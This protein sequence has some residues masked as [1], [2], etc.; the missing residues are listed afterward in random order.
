MASWM[1]VLAG[2]SVALACAA[3]AS[4]QTSWRLSP[5]GL[6]PVR[7]GMS[8]REA[9]RAL[10]MTAPPKPGPEAESEAC[11]EFEAG[12][13]HPGVFGMISN[14]RL[15]RLTINAP[16]T[17]V[18]DHGVGVGAAEAEVVK[19]YGGK[20]KVEPHAYEEKPAHYLTSRTPDRT[21]AIKYSTDN[22]RSVAGIDAGL[23]GPVGY[24]EGCL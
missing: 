23:T 11:W 13:R 3:D 16:S 1:S 6:G 17:L 21:H 20:L 7:I 14:G 22:H 15:V 18:S 4:A 8:V 12:D 2:V 5:Y 24:I 19:A 10:S 9:A